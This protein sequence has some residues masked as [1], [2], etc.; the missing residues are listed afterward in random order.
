MQKIR[1]ILKV[2]VEKRS[3]IKN[4]HLF[5]TQDLIPYNPGLRFVYRKTIWLT[6]WA[7]LSPALMQKIRKILKSRFGEKAKKV[8][9][10]FV[11][12]EL[13]FFQK[14]HLS[15]TMGTIV[16]YSHEKI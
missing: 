6:Q 13:N 9:N 11:G 5:W 16:L 7:L 2:V 15:Q 4:K 3:K 14:S 1:R 10:I 12:H 8:K